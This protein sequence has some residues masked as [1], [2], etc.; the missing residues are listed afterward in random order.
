MEAGHLVEEVDGVAKVGCE[1]ARNP[2]P[3]LWG[4]EALLHEGVHRLSDV[5]LIERGDLLQHHIF[6]GTRGGFEAR[7][8]LVLGGQLLARLVETCVRVSRL[9]HRMTQL[10]EELGHDG[11]SIG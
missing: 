9:F 4:N 6:T 7:D 11:I 10:V 5:A 8:L 1:V 2:V 3:V